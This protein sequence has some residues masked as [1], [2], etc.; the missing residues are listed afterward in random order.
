MSEIIR[1]RFLNPQGQESVVDVA[2]PIDSLVKTL[3]ELSGC[4]LVA[5]TMGP[6]PFEF[7][8]TL[9]H[10]TFR[11]EDLIPAFLEG[12]YRIDPQAHC[13]L[14]HKAVVPMGVDP[15]S[16]KD[17]HS[18]WNSKSAQWLLEDLF[19]ALNAVAPEGYYFGGHPG[20]GSDFGFWKVEG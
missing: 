14:Y 10:A 9:I 6:E 8:G 3:N 12:L 18:W 1:I 17:G 4:R 19:D 5:T 20:D 7:L 2:A 16:L 15:L 11:P 13:D